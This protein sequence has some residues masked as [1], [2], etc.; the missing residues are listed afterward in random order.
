MVPNVMHF[1]DNKLHFMCVACTCVQL[2]SFTVLLAN[3][4]TEKKTVFVFFGG[5]TVSAALARKAR[6][7]FGMSIFSGN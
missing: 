7:L 1:K 4:K 2:A 5:V 6:N 3:N